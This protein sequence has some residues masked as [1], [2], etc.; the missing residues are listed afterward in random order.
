MTDGYRW[1]FRHALRQASQIRGAPAIAHLAQEGH[2]V[3]VNQVEAILRVDQQIGFFQVTVG[4]PFIVQLGDQSPC[5]PGK[6]YFHLAVFAQF[7][8]EIDRSGD[9]FHHHIASDQQAAD[10][11]AGH[12]KPSRSRDSDKLKMV[13]LSKGALCL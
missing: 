6:G 4:K 10:A 11:F 2:A 9:F 7:R 5:L 8:A 12:G 1:I 13:G 3:E